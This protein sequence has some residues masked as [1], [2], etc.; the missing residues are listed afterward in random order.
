[1]VKLQKSSQPKK[2]GAEG[3]ST[4]SLA[5]YSKGAKFLRTK[6]EVL[7]VGRNGCWE[8]FLS[9]IIF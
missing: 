9:F 4:K 3:R 5:Y 1:M 7:R 2:G 6:K 8:I